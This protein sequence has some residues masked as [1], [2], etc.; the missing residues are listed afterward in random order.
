MSISVAE[1]LAEAHRALDGSS[2]WGG[3]WPR[4]AA[5]LGR[6]ALEDAIDRLWN[7]V[8][9]A[10]VNCSMAT[11]LLCLPYLMED[12]DVG[13]RARHCWYALSAACHAHP[14]ELAPTV[15]ELRGWLEEVQAFEFATS[16]Q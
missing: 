11:Q 16:G 1:L 12:E 8:A 13:L 15:S 4:A 3:A 2:T 14:Y 7:T 5:F 10:M 9:P 6:Q